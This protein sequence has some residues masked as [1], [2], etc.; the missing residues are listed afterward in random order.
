[1]RLLNLQQG[2][3]P[4]FDWWGQAVSKMNLSIKTFQQNIKIEKHFIANF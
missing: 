4:G 2:C 3:K 1:M